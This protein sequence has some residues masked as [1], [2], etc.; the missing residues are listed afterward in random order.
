VTALFAL[1]AAS[2]AMAATGH[3][4]GPIK[5]IVPSR[6]AHSGTQGSGTINNLIFHGGSVLDANTAYAIFW[7]PSNWGTQIPASYES[8]I[9]RYF[10]D[11][12]HDTSAGLSSN[13]YY[14]DTQYGAGTYGSTATSPGSLHNFS[15]FGGAYIDHTAISSGCRDRA[16]SVCVTDAQVVQEINNDLTQAKSGWTAG[17]GKIFFVFTAK[18]VGSCYSGGSCSFTQWCAYHSNS[19]STLY[20]NMPYAD[21][22][23]RACDAGYHPNSSTDP[24]ADATINVT[25]HEHNETITDPFGTAWFDSSGYE[26]GDKCAWTFGSVSNSAN[27]TINGHPYI[28]QQEWSNHSAACKLSGV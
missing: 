5:G 2:S 21:T 9:G 11:V 3:E 24:E 1:G 7:S 20:A 23:A 25:S 22:S 12:A 14:S 27:Q 17:T 18:G 19:G 15:T 13:V 28:L 6:D 16:T 10:S 8:L 4:H 26:N